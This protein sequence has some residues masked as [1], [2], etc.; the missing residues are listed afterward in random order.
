MKG[1][2]MTVE[3]TQTKDN[4]SVVSFETLLSEIRAVNQKDRTKYL[5]LLSMMI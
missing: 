5:E 3:E 2:T 1:V 4:S